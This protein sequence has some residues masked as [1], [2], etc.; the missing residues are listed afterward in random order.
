MCNPATSGTGVPK[1]VVYELRDRDIGLQ[2]SRK[3]PRDIDIIYLDAKGQPIRDSP[4]PSGDRANIEGFSNGETDTVGKSTSEQSPLADDF[5]NSFPDD[6]PSSDTESYE[7]E[8]PKFP[9][10]IADIEK[11]FPPEGI[12]AG[13]IKGLSSDR[14][15]KAQ[16]FIDQYGTVEG[17][18]R[19]REIEPDAAE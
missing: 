12:E 4:A 13:L 6:L 15:N 10:S 19:F 16:Q 8:K 1:W 14:F 17:L 18:R 2:P 11:Q 9:Q 3:I 5:D 7:F